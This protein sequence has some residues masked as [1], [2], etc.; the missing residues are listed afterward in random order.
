MTPARHRPFARR[1]PP[2]RGA[3]LLVAMVLLT[4]VSTLAAGMVWQQ[5]RAVQVEAAERSRVQ[6]AWLLSGALDWARLILREDAR[7]GRPTSLHEPWATPLQETKVSSILAVD[8]N[9]NAA[10]DAGDNGGPEAFI[11]GSIADAQARYNLRHLVADGKLVPEQVAV[12]ARLC[13]LAGLSTDVA[14]RLATQYLAALLGSEAESPLMPQT[15]D[16]LRWLGL[17]AAAVDRLRPFIVVLPVATPLNLNTAAREVLAAVVP[18]VDLGSADRLVQARQRRAFASLEQA[19]AVLGSKVPLPISL[20]D[21]RSQF[22]DV[23]GQL[24]L[25][26]RLVGERLLVQRRDGLD[27]AAIQRQRQ[28][29][30]AQDTR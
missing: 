17:D 15:M 10:Q 11:A 19:S 26:D 29:G 18:G 9:N 21:V 14:E 2:A 3:A 20:V 22:F 27:V 16:D 5:W 30:Y 24:R 28:S 6:S 12:L 23:A 13:T 25:D 8:R 1:H 7:S 4:V